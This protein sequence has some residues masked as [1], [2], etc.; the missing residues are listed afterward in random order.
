MPS[1][2]S[3][4]ISE[5]KMPYSLAVDILYVRSRTSARRYGQAMWWKE[6]LKEFERRWIR[7]KLSDKHSLTVT[8][9]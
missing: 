2:R 8:S 1:L 5:Q 9:E 6:L 3:K 4:Q 7:E